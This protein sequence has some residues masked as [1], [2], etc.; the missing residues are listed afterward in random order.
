M[1]SMWRWAYEI[2]R[3]DL[4][5]FLSSVKKN[6]LNKKN[7]KGGDKQAR[8]GKNFTSN[9]KQ[10]FK[11]NGAIIVEFAVAVP[12]FVI[13]IFYAH[14]L[15]LYT[16]LYAKTKFCAY[17]IAN[18]I[19]SVSQNRNN[20]KITMTDLQ[21]IRCAASLIAYPGKTGYA[22]KG[23]GDGACRSIGHFLSL[24]IYCVIGTG[25]NKGK[26]VWR[27]DSNYLN[28]SPS[29]SGSFNSLSDNS[30]AV[31]RYKNNETDTKN[32]WKDLT[33]E[34]GEMKIIIETS[35]RTGLCSYSDGQRVS[36]VPISKRFGFWL[37]TPTCPTPIGHGSHFHSVVIFSPKPGL[38]DTNTPT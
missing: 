37:I 8:L 11:H 35:L 7:M 23:T 19:G 2:V 33:I 26:C 27:W 15:V 12:I 21:N 20:K 14:D 34:N 5:I 16:R 25:N 32:I 36:S 28:T 31:V 18:M 6:F 29:N 9:W 4:L 10:F 22:I 1:F 30:Y 3:H 17:C 24:Y 13:L 38:F